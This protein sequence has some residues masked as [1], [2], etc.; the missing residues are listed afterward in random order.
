MEIP[1]YI[2]PKIFLLGIRKS[3]NYTHAYY[4]EKATVTTACGVKYEPGSVGWT[5]DNY[6]STLSGVDALPIVNVG[7][8][9][10]ATQLIGIP[11]GLP[12]G[13]LAPAY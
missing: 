3:K 10:L 1:A 8:W 7:D 2:S 11:V 6:A 5:P 9:E 4:V 13:V 12:G